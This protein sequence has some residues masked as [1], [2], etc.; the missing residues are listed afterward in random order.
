MEADISDVV[1][2]KADVGDDIT[3]GDNDGGTNV[4][5]PDVSSDVVELPTE[6]H[7][8]QHDAEHIVSWIPKGNWIYN[9]PD[10]EMRGFAT[11]V[12]ALSTPGPTHNEQHVLPYRPTLNARPTSNS[13]LWFNMGGAFLKRIGSVQIPDLSMTD[14]CMNN[15]LMRFG[16]SHSFQRTLRNWKFR[17]GS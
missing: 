12:H 8:I 3:M 2:S 11:S 13:R 10:V 16:Y 14:P 1:M 9:L 6:E 15:L 7:E 4:V 5:P 17:N